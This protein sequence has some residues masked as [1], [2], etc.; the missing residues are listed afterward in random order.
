M[1]GKVPRRVHK[2]FS[3]GFGLEVSEL[4]F[5]RKCWSW[6]KALDVVVR[7]LHEPSLVRLREEWSMWEV[8]KSSIFELKKLQ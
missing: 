5:A 8:S 6:S 1:C 7:P 2:V 3:A 4:S